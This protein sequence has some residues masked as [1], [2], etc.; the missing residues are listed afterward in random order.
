MGGDDIKN[1]QQQKIVLLLRSHVIKGF[2]YLLTT[3]LT[4]SRVISG[5]PV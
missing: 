1:S 3:S 4:T 5:D 2:T